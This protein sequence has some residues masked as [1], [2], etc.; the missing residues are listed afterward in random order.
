MLQLVFLAR[1]CSAAQDMWCS[2]ADHYLTIAMATNGNPKSYLHRRKDGVPLD[3]DAP[4]TTV[5]A[6]APPY[7]LA[8]S[9]QHQ[10]SVHSRGLNPTHLR[11]CGAQSISGLCPRI[12]AT[13]AY[14]AG[15]EPRPPFGPH[16]GADNKLKISRAVGSRFDTVFHHQPTNLSVSKFS[17]A[18]NA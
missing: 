17:R 9:S 5:C 14:R 18:G 1:A 11:A 12:P 15:P 10:Q 4:A 7:P 13:G 16:Q 3:T 6:S 8:P 2:A